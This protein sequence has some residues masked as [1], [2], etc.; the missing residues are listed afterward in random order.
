MYQE[1]VPPL[2]AT[3]RSSLRATISVMTTLSRQQNGFSNKRSPG[4]TGSSEAIPLTLDTD[5]RVLARVTDGI[6]RQPSS[7]IRELLANAEGMLTRRAIY[8]AW[9]DSAAAPARKTLWK[10]LS[11]VVKE[12]HVLLHGSGTRKDP[13]RYSLPGMVE[14][15]HAN[16]VAEFTRS[17]ERDEG[18]AGQPPPS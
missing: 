12:G 6:Y 4:P 2:K 7:A 17:L 10:W 5:D 18:R 14:K 3:S 15:W 1:P 11:R 9:P 8:H 16:F 13:Y